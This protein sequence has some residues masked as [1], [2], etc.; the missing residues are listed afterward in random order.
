MLAIPAVTLRLV[1]AALV[2]VVFARAAP[3]VCAAVVVVAPP[4]ALE[5]VDA[6]ASPAVVEVASVACGVSTVDVVLPGV[7]EEEA[8][9]PPPHADTTRPTHIASPTNETQRR[10]S[11]VR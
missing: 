6:V 11:G 1:T 2:V 10:P 3:A 9:F 8:F 7:D 4:T 5:A